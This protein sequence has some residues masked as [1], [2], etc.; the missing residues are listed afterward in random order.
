MQDCDGG[1]NLT[2]LKMRG[3]HPEHLE[4][5]GPNKGVEKASEP[6]AERHLQIEQAVNVAQEANNKQNSQ[7]AKQG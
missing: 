6:K 2:V 7:K 3:I 4:V 1:H 5:C